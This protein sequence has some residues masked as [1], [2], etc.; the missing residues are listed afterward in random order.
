M[1]NNLKIVRSRYILAT[2]IVQMY[3]D[4]FVD[5]NPGRT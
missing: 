1:G 3:G 2:Q 5:T 4:K